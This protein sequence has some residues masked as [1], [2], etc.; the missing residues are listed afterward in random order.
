MTME[1]KYLINLT[2]EAVMTVVLLFLLVTCFLQ[3]RRL[4]KSRPLIWL[5]LVNTLLLLCQMVEWKLM[6]ASGNQMAAGEIVYRN[7][8]VISYTLDYTL[9][10]FSSLTFFYYVREHIRDRYVQGGQP[11]SAEKGGWMKLM[12]L[13][14]AV[15]A[16]LYGGLMSRD[17]FYYL[18][19]DGR[20][21]FHWQGY[22]FI[23][24]LATVPTVATV[25]K[26]VLHRK[27]LGR[28]S[29]LLLLFYKL[30]PFGLLIADL[31][32]GTC[33]TYLMRAFY[34]F[35]L[36]VH[37]DLRVKSD[38]AERDALL[39]RQ[40]KELLELRTQIM[41]SQIQPH[42]LYNTLTTISGLCYFGNSQQA[43]EV[44][45]KLADYLRENLDSM[46][47][48]KIIPF[49]KELEHIKT[50]LWIEQVRFGDAV[51]AEYRIGV[52]DFTLP[53]LTLQP[54]VE[55]AVK[56][57]IR[58]KK[59][60]GTVTIETAETETEYLIYIKDDGVGFDPTQKPT[61]GRTHVGIENIT[62]R[63]ELLCGG[64]CG[65]ESKKGEGTTVTVHLPKEGTP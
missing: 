10:Y 5:T 44:V 39:A 61:D 31:I 28:V 24:L 29:F 2:A 25:I 42:F 30:S 13:W 27:I 57:G 11:Q 47:K 4:P 40:E 9:G 22:L 62:K 26:L 12:A 16:V 3:R 37:I 50:Y 54:L 56:H 51:R 1:N 34:T 53:S 20:E 19:P 18:L 52:T 7:W 49:E 38:F 41:L 46:G 45:D 8:K 48:N 32:N 65:F 23:Y 6:L 17:W 33:F 60:G 36:Y 15:S 35:I 59:G 63:L 58:K 43:R 55:N 64:S 21:T 14:G